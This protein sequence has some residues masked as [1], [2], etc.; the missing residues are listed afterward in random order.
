MSTL[1]CTRAVVPASRAAA[2]IASTAH[3]A[4][5]ERS[6]SARIPS[7]HCSSR[8]DS[9]DSTRGPVTPAA[10]SASASSSRAVPSQVAPP[11]AA[12]FAEGTSPWP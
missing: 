9:Q 5:A 6:M 1:R 3:T 12:A 7:T 4:L 10:R 8:P 11:A 2:A